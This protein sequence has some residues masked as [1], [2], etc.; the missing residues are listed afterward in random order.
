[1]LEFGPKSKQMMLRVIFTPLF[2]ELMKLVGTT[3]QTN[4][5]FNNNL[6]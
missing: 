5:F 6:L 3:K 1:M 4:V 2:L